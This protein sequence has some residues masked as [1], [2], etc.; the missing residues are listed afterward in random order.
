MLPRLWV[1][2]KNPILFRVSSM[3]HKQQRY[4][5]LCRTEWSTSSVLDVLDEWL[6]D[7]PRS[8]KHT[9]RAL[10]L[11]HEQSYIWRS[12]IVVRWHKMLQVSAAK[13]PPPPADDWTVK[14]KI[15]V[16]PVAVWRKGRDD[17]DFFILIFIL[18]NAVWYYTTVHK[19]KLTHWIVPMQN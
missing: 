2:N 18:W 12:F 6:P 19:N 17:D 8:Y 15:H 4:V 10:D 5:D 3:W 11:H 14:P 13:Q 7:Q 1:G 9:H 16:L